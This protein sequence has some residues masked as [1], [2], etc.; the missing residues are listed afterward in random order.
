MAARYLSD[1]Q[2]SRINALRQKHRILSGQLDQA[3]KSVSVSDFYLTQL[4][5]Q[6]LFLK[7]QIEGLRV[8]AANEDQRQ[9]A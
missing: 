3:R 2:I 8:H 7:E 4:K 1:T 9:S 6:K 5:K